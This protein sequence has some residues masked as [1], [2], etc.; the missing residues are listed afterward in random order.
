MRRMGAGGMPGAWVERD[1]RRTVWL[2]GGLLLF[3]AGVVVVAFAVNALRSGPSCHGACVG[4]PS[5]EATTV[6]RA[7][8]GDPLVVLV[9]SQED[10]GS[11]TAAV[12]SAAGGAVG[13]VLGG[14][15]MLVSVLRRPG[16]T[17]RAPETG[18]GAE[19]GAPAP[20]PAEEPRRDA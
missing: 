19:P 11:D 16:T 10:E 17:G 3:A 9:P 2:Y 12:I 4:S 5:G 14:T 15:A 7:E 13:A 18:T 1:R 20:R 6:G 8:D